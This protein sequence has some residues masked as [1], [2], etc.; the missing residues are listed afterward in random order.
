MKVQKITWLTSLQH[1]RKSQCSLFAAHT[2]IS[3]GNIT[4]FSVWRKIFLY[5][6]FIGLTVTG[7]FSHYGVMAQAR[8]AE[9]MVRLHVLANSDTYEDQQLK[10]AVRDSIVQYLS[11]K[12][13][14]SNSPSDAKAIIE[15]ELDNIVAVARETIL[16]NDYDYEVTAM[17]GNFSFPTRVY[18]QF[19]IPEG[20]YDA[21]RIL[22]GEGEGQNWWCVLYPNLCGNPVQGEK[23]GQV[24]SEDDYELVIMP[25]FKFRIVE[26]FSRK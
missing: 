23:L 18:G 13:D 11:D 10:L 25:T 4:A 19:S 1:Q 8:I 17:L 9:Q 26:I 2:P 20:R 14:D 6:L 22:I 16:S 7:A 5:S 21:L 24:L 12:M 15:S 3:H